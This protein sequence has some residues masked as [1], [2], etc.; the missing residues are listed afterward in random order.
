MVLKK[1]H[2]PCVRNS[3]LILEG[4]KKK[5]LDTIDGR[6]DHVHLVLHLNRGLRGEMNQTCR[7]VLTLS[8]GY[9]PMREWGEIIIFQW[10]WPGTTCERQMCASQA[11]ERKLKK[12]KNVDK[13]RKLFKSKTLD[14][15][16]R[17]IT[18]SHLYWLRSAVWNCQVYFLAFNLRNFQK[19]QNVINLFQ[20]DSGLSL[21]FYF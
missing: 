15:Y 16:K 11:G 17:R 2:S 3:W 21:D 20:R 1:K 10:K 6:R 19:L 12:C 4:F 8:R 7:D 5:Y 9:F 14:G 13:L 18:N